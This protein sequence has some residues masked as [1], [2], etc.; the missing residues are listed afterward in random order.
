[1]RLVELDSSRRKVDILR[2]GE[3]ATIRARAAA[4]GKTGSRFV[5]DLALADD[6][7]RHPVA[8]T[9]AEQTELHD[10]GREVW[11]FVCAV[12]QAVGDSG[13]SLPEA[14]RGLRSPSVA[15]SGG[16][17]VIVAAV[18][19]AEALHRRPGFDQRAVD[20]KMLLRQQPPRR[21]PRGA[22]PYPLALQHRPEEARRHLA[23]HQAV[24]ALRVRSR[25]PAGASARAAC[26]VSVK[27]GH[28]LVAHRQ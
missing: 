23:R 10:R 11:I 8:L 15:P 1:M 12:K 18:F 16:G 17:R 22:R 14:I 9:V 26:R 6:P 25:P 3:Q 7:E 5:L 20:R 4:A 13:L 27:D 19:A 21:S 2:T 24:A 28:A